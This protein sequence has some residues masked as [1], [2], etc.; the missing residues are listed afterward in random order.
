[1]SVNRFAICGKFTRALLAHQIFFNMN[2]M[3]AEKQAHFFEET[4]PLLCILKEFGNLAEFRP[5]R[6]SAENKIT[7]HIAESHGTT[8]MSELYEST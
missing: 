2:Q 5:N 1:V 7:V 4:I 8:K 3:S 6:R